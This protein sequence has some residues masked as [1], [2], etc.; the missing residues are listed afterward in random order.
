M[1]VV[2]PFEGSKV[3][4]KGDP[5]A[6]EREQVKPM[7]GL[8]GMRGQWQS[9][10]G[11]VGTVLVSKSTKAME[12]SLELSWLQDSESRTLPLSS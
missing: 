10:V 6:G 4:Q 5:K 12:I 1:Q 11:E 8:V 2:V 3:V 9:S 7:D